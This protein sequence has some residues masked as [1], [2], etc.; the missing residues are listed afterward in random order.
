MVNIQQDISNTP[1]SIDHWKNN[2]FV[3]KNKEKFIVQLVNGIEEYHI[4]ETDCRIEAE[5]LINRSM[6][7]A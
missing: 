5:H 1:V 3:V 6:H 7:I 2:H 4:N